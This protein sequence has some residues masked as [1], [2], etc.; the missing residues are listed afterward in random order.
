LNEVVIHPDSF[1]AIKRP[2]LNRT[3]ITSVHQLLA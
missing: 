3:F 2:S 1:H